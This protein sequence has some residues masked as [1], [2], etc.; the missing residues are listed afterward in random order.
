M[1][2]SFMLTLLCSQI[3]P[4]LTLYKSLIHRTREASKVDMGI[5]VESPFPVS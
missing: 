1:K 5:D 4:H 3:S 2:D